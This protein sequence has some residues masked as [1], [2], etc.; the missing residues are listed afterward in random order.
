METR[1]DDQAG[2]KK[3]GGEAFDQIKRC[4]VYNTFRIIG[5]KFTILIIRDMMY[6]DKSR[7]NEFLET[8][9]EI[10]PKTLSARLRE[11]EK[12]G[13]IRRKIHHER[14]VR[15]EYALTEKGKALRPI[16][17]QMSEFSFR[18]CPRDVFRDGKPRIVSEV[19]ASKVLAGDRGGPGVQGK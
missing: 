8:V 1:M 17:E 7:F 3:G 10:N 12:D 4:P 6:N 5:K 15:V 9:E 13:L 14:P 18:Y 19:V 2:R 11:M 16:L